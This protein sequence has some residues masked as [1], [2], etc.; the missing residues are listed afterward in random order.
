M[1]LFIIYVFVSVHVYIDSTEGKNCREV[2]TVLY[3]F[4]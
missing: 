3:L 1:S 2:L 4:V